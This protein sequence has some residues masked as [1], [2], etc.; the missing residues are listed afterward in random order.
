MGEPL[1]EAGHVS[2]TRW[3]LILRVSCVVCHCA[4][5]TTAGMP[6]PG[7]WIQDDSTFGAR[8]ALVRFRMGWNMKEAALACGVPAASWRGW[9]ADG[10]LPRD[11]V[12]IC[13]VISSRTLC[14][15]GW[16]REG[17]PSGEPWCAV[18][19]S[20]PEPAGSEP[21]RW[22]WVPNLLQLPVAM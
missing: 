8:L 2:R 12:A 6:R 13:R 3:C 16:L 5:M 9:E 21:R 11:Y 19:D 15:Y 14:D 1:Q 17:E 7:G 22:S 18:R 10:S 20:N 4:R